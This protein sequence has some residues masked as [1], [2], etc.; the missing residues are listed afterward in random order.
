DR[1]L[2]GFAGLARVLR[3]ADLCHRPRPAHLDEHARQRGR[4]CDPGVAALATDDVRD[5]HL[6]GLCDGHRLDADPF[7]R[8]ASPAARSL[9]H[10]ADAADDRQ[11]RRADRISRA[12]RPARRRDR[13]GWHPAGT[14]SRPGRIRSRGRDDAAA[15][16]VLTRSLARKRMPDAIQ[17]RMGGYGPASTGFSR[18]LKRMGDRLTAEFGERVEIKYVWNIMELGYRVED[19]LWLVEHGLLPLGYQSSSYLTDRVR[20][21]GIVDLPF[22]F[23]HTQAARGDGRRARRPARAQDRGARE[24]PRARL[25]RERLSAHLESRKRGARARGSGGLED[26]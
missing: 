21:L 10:R 22:L 12:R 1:P 5:S 4:V 9:R 7:R 6:P 20:E 23:A 16:D 8:H 17:I 14:R 18:A 3:P 2:A 26:P 19:I 15:A 13:R 25:V 24:L 11:P